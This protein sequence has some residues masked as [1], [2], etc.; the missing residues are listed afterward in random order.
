MSGS[1]Q[2]VDD[3]EID[4]PDDWDGDDDD[5]DDDDDGNDPCPHCGASIY[6]DS[7]RCPICGEY[8]SREDTPWTP[9]PLWIVLGVAAGLYAVY[10]WVVR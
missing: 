6:G 1:A 2:L 10:T 9:K 3:D 8:L 4:G 5:D 7:E